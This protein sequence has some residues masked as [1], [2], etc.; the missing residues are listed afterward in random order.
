MSVHSSAEKRKACELAEREVSKST[1]K[2]KSCR[3]PSRDA[4]AV[5]KLLLNI[6]YLNWSSRTHFKKGRRARAWAGRIRASHPIFSRSSP[7]SFSEQAASFNVN[8]DYLTSPR[9]SFLIC[10]SVL[11]AIQTIPRPP[12]DSKLWVWSTRSFKI[13]EEIV[14]IISYRTVSQNG[15]V[16]VTSIK[17]SDQAWVQSWSSWS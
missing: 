1:K 12:K 16:Q 8:A 5:R 6:A 17:D 7:T 10:A 11:I 4:N 13:I 2:C 3:I 15:E 9:T 14:M